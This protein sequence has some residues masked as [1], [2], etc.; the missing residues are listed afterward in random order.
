MGSRPVAMTTWTWAAAAQSGTSHERSGVPLQDAYACFTA[1]RDDFET[2]VG[3]V[4]DGAGSASFGGQGAWLVCRALSVAL[5]AHFRSSSKLPTDEHF[6]NWLDVIRDQIA[7]V[8]GRRLV[9]SREFASTLICVASNGAQSVVAHIGDGCAVFRLADEDRWIAPLWPD[10]GEYISTT[11]FV[12][13]DDGAQLRVVGIDRSISA[14]ALFSDGLERLALDFAL[15]EPFPNFFSG[16]F[17]PIV[18]SEGS[19]RQVLLS[20]QLAR[21][22]SGA[23]V[24]ARTDDDKSLILAVRR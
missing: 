19:G 16:I 13:D 9:A 2:F 20:A 21:Y 6:S 24:N 15:H 14:L 10:H 3:I 22:L 18:R 7:A 12:T 4:A 1:P 17:A 11:R 5:R 23:A 8:A